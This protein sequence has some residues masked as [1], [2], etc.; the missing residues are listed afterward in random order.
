MVY[1]TALRFLYS[2]FKG[3]AKAVAT[4]HHHRHHLLLF[5]FLFLLLLY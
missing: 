5:I 1:L 4:H 3:C 2:E